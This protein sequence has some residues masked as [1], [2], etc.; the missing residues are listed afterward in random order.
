M[1]NCY[2]ILEAVAS[3]NKGSATELSCWSLE[4]DLSVELESPCPPPLASGLGYFLRVQR[5]RSPKK[6]WDTSAIWFTVSSS[7]ISS[8]SSSMLFTAFFPSFF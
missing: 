5:G 4:P 3:V 2:G 8:Q 1:G 7:R 6:W